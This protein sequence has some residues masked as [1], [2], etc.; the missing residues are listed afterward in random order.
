M[1]RAYVLP[2][3]ILLSLVAAMFAAVMLERATAQRGTTRRLL[4]R[5]QSTHD[6]R[7]MRELID[8]WI[9][10]LPSGPLDQ[11]V[12][13][14]GHA[15]DVEIPDGSF[16][17]VYIFDG[18][19]TARLDGGRLSEEEGVHAD[20][21]ANALEA[22]GAVPE[23]LWR[24][25]G[26]AAVSVRSADERVIEAVVSYAMDGEAPASLVREIIRRAESD[27][28]DRPTLGIEAVNAGATSEQRSLLLD[29]ISTDPSLWTVYVERRSAPPS[30][31]RSRII[32]LH[33]GMAVVRADAST[34]GQR[35]SDQTSFLTWEELDP[36]DADD[37]FNTKGRSR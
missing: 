24:R 9:S 23:E 2:M 35:L 20:G 5:Y 25:V 10:S 7:G 14:D 28:F 12:G 31:P 36:D 4:D 33:K 30:S 29:L 18:Q 15:L 34:G 22:Q 16:V 26:P 3:V 11:L 1:R 19:G 13:I 32:S 27:R 17:S 21:I 6:E 8:Q 37:A